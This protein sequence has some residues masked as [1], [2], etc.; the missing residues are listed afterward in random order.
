MKADEIVHQSVVQL[1]HPEERA[2]AVAALDALGRGAVDFYR[3]HRRLMAPDGAQLVSTE[4]LHGFEVGGRRLALAEAAPGA[5]RGRTP[6]DGYFGRDPGVI[7][8]GAIDSACRVTAVSKDVHELLELDAADL[9]GKRLLSSVARQDVGRL[10]AA[11]RESREHSVGL[12]IDMR[13]GSGAWLQIC[14]LLTLVADDAEQWFMLVRDPPDEG[15]DAR[16]AE[17]ERHLW[18][19]AGEVEAS[20]V[21]HRMMPVTSVGQFAQL[22]ALTIRQWEV[23]SRIA[24]GERVPTIAKELYVSQSTVRNHLS[25]IFERFGV[26]SQAELLEALRAPSAAATDPS[27]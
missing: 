24:R 17:L 4:W 16:A 21:L 2:M 26:H 8:V 3:A 27:S 10:R 19:I 20:G 5:A 13:T 25:A 22:N 11:S 18:R 1:V 7:V 14:V 15:G 9:I 12:T 23:L 6:L